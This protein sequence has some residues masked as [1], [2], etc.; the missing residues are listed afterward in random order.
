MSPSPRKSSLRGP[1][2]NVHLFH[3]VSAKLRFIHSKSNPEVARKPG[4]CS[5][6]LE[7]SIQLPRQSGPLGGR[8][9]LFGNNVATPYKTPLAVFYKRAYATPTATSSTSHNNP[10]F[11]GFFE[12]KRSSAIPCSAFYSFI[13]AN[14]PILKN[15]IRRCHACSRRCGDC[16]SEREGLQA[17]GYPVYVTEHDHVADLR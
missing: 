15:E 9:D 6:D 14:F 3:G 7:C 12:Q 17:A 5:V 10:V 13:R 11:F 4:D 2:R 16:R 1:V 8:N